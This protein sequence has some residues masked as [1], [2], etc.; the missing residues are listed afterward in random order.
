[1]HLFHAISNSAFGTSCIHYQMT[2]FSPFVWKMSHLEEPNL[3]KIIH[4]QTRRKTLSNYIIQILEP[5]LKLQY[6]IT[7]LILRLFQSVQWMATRY[8]TLPIPSRGKDCSS[9]KTFH[10]GFGSIQAYN[11]WKR[12]TSIS[13]KSTGAWS[14]Q[15]PS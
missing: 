9:S 8:S 15:V 1:M 12:D 11:L 7:C 6:P 4:Y 13:V 2:Y 3:T 14:C 5:I 10:A